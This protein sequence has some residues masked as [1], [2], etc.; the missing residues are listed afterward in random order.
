MA[1]S[2]QVFIS[3]KNSD[4]QG[5]PTRDSQLADLL[6][7]EFTSRGLDV[8]YSNLSLPRLGE[9]EYKKCID[10]ALDSSTVLIA[11]GT[12]RENLESKWV[13]YEWDSFYNDVLSGVKPQGRLFVYYEKMST[14]ELPR[15]LRQNQAFP[16]GL[17]HLNELSEYIM[18]ALPASPVPKFQDLAICTNCGHQFDQRDP[19][20]CSYHPEPALHVKSLG[21]RDDYRE[22]YRFPCCDSFAFA[23]IDWARGGT[24]VPPSRFPGC[25]QGRCIAG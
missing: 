21:A 20:H 14:K 18:R 9:S 19:P 4:E 8:F 22:V 3:F 24:D 5:L 10:D 16:H 25:K 13:R 23:A 6:Y 17:D 2:Y 15:T 11:V 12:S 1:H 7:R